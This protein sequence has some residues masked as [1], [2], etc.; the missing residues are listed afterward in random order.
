VKAV[1]QLVSLDMIKLSPDQVN[2]CTPGG[3][4]LECAGLV[5]EITK[6]RHSHPAC[7]SFMPKVGLFDNI[8]PFITNNRVP[9]VFIVFE[10]VGEKTERV[11]VEDR[12]PVA[13]RNCN[14]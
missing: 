1:G 8:E 14:E 5:R 2:H 9:T 6:M 12:N 4:G 11:L 13:S 10:L 3:G 7:V